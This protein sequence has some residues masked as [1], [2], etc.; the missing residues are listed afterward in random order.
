[1]LSLAPPATMRTPTQTTLAYRCETTATALFSTR[2]ILLAAYRAT[3]PRLAARWLRAE[4]DRLA[5]LLDPDPTTPAL[6]NAPLFRTTSAVPRP[7]DGLRAWARD[8]D[9]YARTQCALAAGDAFLLTVTDYDA[10][11]AIT[12][13]PLPT[14]HPIQK[15]PAPAGCHSPPLA[16]AGRHRRTIR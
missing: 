14:S 8:A 16:G 1:M 13:S 12:A 9:A 15:N 5:G 2:E 6:R 3:T 7:A 11:Y 4:A 10:R